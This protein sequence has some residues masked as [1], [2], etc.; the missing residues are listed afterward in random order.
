VKRL[1]VF[2]ALLLLAACAEQEVLLEGERLDLNGNPIPVET[3]NRAAPLALPPARVNAEWTHLGG[4]VRHQQDHVALRRPLG[5]A[6]SVEIGQGNSR[7]YRLAADPVVAGGR[8]FT[9]DSRARVSAFSTAGAALWSVDLT[10]PEDSE[11]E[12]SGGG[13]AIAGGTLFVTSGFGTLSALDAATGAVRWTHDFHA[14]ATGAPTV[15]NGVVYAVTANATGWAID[16]RS[17][18]ILWQVVGAA[19]ERGIA[20]GGPSPAV[21]GPLVIFPFSSGQM[22]AAVASEGAQ[23]WAASVAGGRL[24][25]GFSAVT[26]LTGGPVV[27][28]NTIY[29][30]SHAGRAG[31]YD[32]TTGSAIWRAEEGSAGQ[33][34]LAGRA[35][36]MVTDDNRL[37]RLDAATGETVW[38]QNLPLFTRSRI[39]RRKATFV[40]YGPVLA[41]G[42]LIVA[43]DD[44]I[45]RE[46]DPVSGAFIGQQALPDGAARNPV[47]AGGTLY[48]V[49][50][51]GRLNALR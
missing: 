16:A 27:S 41:G 11:S 10:P 40:H 4:N 42:R 2:I 19:G 20:G 39:K 33:I 49:T 26:D 25:R 12:G 48:L 14:A 8:I 50:E 30:A 13:L 38:A 21:A 51:N 1:A 15:E 36:F 7:K 31:A 18:R 35:L 24:G 46:F 6:W 22:V 47:I 28:G 44:G 3:A 23:T 43:S 5:L 34:W 45:L 29:A 9:M 37:V 32:A 17:G